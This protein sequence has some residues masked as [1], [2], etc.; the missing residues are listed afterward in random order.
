MLA[1]GISVIDPGHHIEVLCQSRLLDI[2]RQWQ[3]KENWD[4]SFVQSTEDTNPFRFY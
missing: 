1:E 3:L 2:C 4:V